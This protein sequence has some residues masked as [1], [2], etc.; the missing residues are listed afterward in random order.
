MPGVGSRAVGAEKCGA[1]CEKMLVSRSHTSWISAV[2]T[3]PKRI[4]SNS[5]LSGRGGV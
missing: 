2:W 5:A 1:K 4:L 3:D